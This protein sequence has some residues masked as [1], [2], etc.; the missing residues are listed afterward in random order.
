MDEKSK[1]PTPGHRFRG[2]LR[3]FTPSCECGWTGPTFYGKGGQA[4][5]VQ[6]WHCHINNCEKARAA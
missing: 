6:E 1:P 5:A 2:V 4:G 3:G